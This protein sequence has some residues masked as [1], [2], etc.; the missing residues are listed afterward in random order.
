MAFLLLA[1]SLLS[2]APTPVIPPMI[3]ARTIQAQID[4]SEPNETLNLPTGRIQGSLR[5]SKP[6]T[7]RGDGASRTII[8]SNGQ[9]PVLLASA[10]AGSTINIEGIRFTAASSRSKHRG[11]G[12]WLEGP[13][14]INIKDVLF[15]RTITGKCLGAAIH[16]ET[17][18]KIRME[19]V[20]IKWHEC[21]MAGALVIRPN[22]DVTLIDTLLE[23]NVGQLA[24]AIL[25]TGGYLRLENT[26]FRSNRYA[27]GS[28][29]HSLTISNSEP[30]RLDLVATKMPKE[31]GPPVAVEGN[32]KPQI[33][34]SDMVWPIRPTP[35]YVMSL[36]Q[37]TK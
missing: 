30:S 27:R 23:G 26:I 3:E 29:G 19:G 1:A 6:L 8:I 5:I 20:S 11:V 17:P 37:A 36:H 2:A 32:K 16:A 21:Y 12:V 34:I 4:A 25:I 35:S 28:A 13:G 7:L 22:M 10:P 14:Q 15:R 33:Y 18:V 9:K 24:G 31:F